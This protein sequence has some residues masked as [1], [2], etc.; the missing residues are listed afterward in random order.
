[1]CMRR[2]MPLIAAEVTEGMCAQVAEEE[3]VS[4]AK[5]RMDFV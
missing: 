1:M 4:I 5:Q 2:D 3:P